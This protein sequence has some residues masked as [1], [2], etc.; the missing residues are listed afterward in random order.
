MS[1][2]VC[3]EQEYLECEAVS[4]L[5]QRVFKLEN[6]LALCLMEKNGL[7]DG[8]VRVQKVADDR[9][10]AITSL[11]SAVD[12]LQAH[13]TLLE[14]QAEERGDDALPWSQ[15]CPTC[16]GLMVDRHPIVSDGEWV[17]QLCRCMNP[18]C[19]AIWQEWFKYRTKNEM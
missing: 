14:A 17:N 11:T 18:S 2:H 19:R 5:E 12:N 9:K 16:D 1:D 6:D 13:V 7:R 8:W 4:D 3:S 10:R 15:S